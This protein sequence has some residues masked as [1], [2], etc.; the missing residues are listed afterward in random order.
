[1]SS[2]TQ[3]SQ[4]RSFNTIWVWGSAMVRISSRKSQPLL[5]WSSR[6]ITSSVMTLACGGEIALPAAGDSATGDAI[7]VGVDSALPPTGGACDPFDGSR[8]DVSRYPFCSDDGEVCLPAGPT[9]NS[10]GPDKFF[11]CC[12]GVSVIWCGTAW[13]CGF[14]S[15]DCPK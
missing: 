4:T 15:H 6:V 1:M 10:N 3:S 9:E 2:S 12:S 8:S 13:Y 11:E 7:P 14:T 5:R